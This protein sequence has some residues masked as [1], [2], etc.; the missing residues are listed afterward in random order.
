MGEGKS[1]AEQDLPPLWHY[2]RVDRYAVPPEPAREAVRKGLRSL[3]RSLRGR[4]GA[5]EAIF[6]EEKLGSIPGEVLD[7][8]APAP[9]WEDALGGVTEVLSDWLDTWQP[10]SAVR[11]FVGPPYGGVPEILS[12]WGRAR[13]WRLVEPPDAAQILSGGDLWLAE[14]LEGNRE[15][16]LVF[17]RLERCYLRHFDGLTLLRRL[18]DRL[19]AQGRRCLLGCDTWAWA[20]LGRTLQIDS[21]FPTPFILE[22]FGQERL[23]RWFQELARDSGRQELLFREPDRGKF[24]LPPPGDGAAAEQGAE[25]DTKF[26]QELAAR[27]RGIPGVAWAI[28][29]HSLRSGQEEGNQQKA[30]EE[31]NGSGRRTIWVRPW[32]RLQLPA[33]PERQDRTRLLFVLHALL[34]HQGL[35]AQVLPEMVPLAPTEIVETLHLLKAAGLVQAEEGFWRVTPLGYPAV[36]TYLRSEGFLIDAV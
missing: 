36:R 10:E 1:A 28:W 26:L 8:V 2:L 27:S 34:L 6:A 15:I 7:R 25:V 21:I 32:S 14:Q 30:P 12:G 24:I 33:V 19:L 16:P 31:P 20:F 29:R 5:K 22:A 13:E 18:L 9:R 35:P 17:P 4:R 11:V 23:S 3:W